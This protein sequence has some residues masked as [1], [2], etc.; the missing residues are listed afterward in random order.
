MVG[1][2]SQ[3][4]SP[5]AFSSPSRGDRGRHDE[6]EGPHELHVHVHEP[7]Q[8][9]H[10]HMTGTGEEPERAD[11]VGSLWRQ[12]AHML[13]HRGVLDNASYRFINFPRDQ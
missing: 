11:S 9:R 8:P 2:I 10:V 13:F 5:G 4:E 7:P 1:S 3:A 6:A 12:L